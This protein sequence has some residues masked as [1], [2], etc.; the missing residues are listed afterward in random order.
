ASQLIAEKGF[1]GLRTREVAEK[2]GINHATVHYHFKDKETLIDAVVQMVTEK[3]YQSDLGAPPSP[4]APAHEK[5]AAY[6]HNNLLQR[7]QYPE[8]F[9]VL[10]EFTVRGKRDPKIERRLEELE[11][12]WFARM[13]TE[14]DAGVASGDL[15][16]D[17]DTESMAVMLIT[18]LRGV[19]MQ[20]NNG[21][22]ERYMKIYRLL[23]QSMLIE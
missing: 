8:R 20:P 1:E 7:K 11:E 22:V 23:E 3:I 4:D 2:V 21:H 12:G 9:A 5:I 10:E 6:F 13:Q 14:L 18:L 15:C 19:R 16:A 17:L